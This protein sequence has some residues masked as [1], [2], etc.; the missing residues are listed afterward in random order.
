MKKQVYKISLKAGL[1]DC[2]EF[3]AAVYQLIQEPEWWSA[4][5]VDI[6]AAFDRQI[7]ALK[8]AGTLEE[9]NYNQ[10]FIDGA[11]SVL[12]KAPQVLERE[13]SKMKGEVPGAIKGRII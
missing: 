12:H 4:F 1:D 9:V 11:L 6:T 13:E 3:S 10:G 8:R 7:H 5:L 2:A